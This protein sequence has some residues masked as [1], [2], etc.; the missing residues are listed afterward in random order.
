MTGRG[1]E[2]IV[3]IDAI[4]AEAFSLL[5][6]GRQTTPF[7]ARDPAFDLDKAYR[8]TAAL[9]RL[10]RARGEVPIG[11]KIGFTNRTIWAEYG[12]FAPIWGH[13]YNSSV[14]DLALIGGTFSL[15]GLIEPRIEPEIVFGLAAAPSPGMD[16]TALL[17][18]IDWVAHG[19][20][21]VQSIF[22]AGSLPRRTRSQAMACM[23]P[24]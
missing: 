1:K 11:R 9:A 22:Q 18:C 17:A 13:V 21:I 19:F 8:V 5:G 12:V 2:T 15:A 24:C 16:E 3:D 14:H 4:A 20:E 10:R 7:T 6:S 23:A